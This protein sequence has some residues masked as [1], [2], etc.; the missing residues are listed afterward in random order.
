MSFKPGTKFDKEKDYKIYSYPYKTLAEM[1]CM[2]VSISP[3]SKKSNAIKIETVSANMAKAK[4][5]INS[6]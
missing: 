6:S 5:I 4:D 1:Y 2:S 3:V